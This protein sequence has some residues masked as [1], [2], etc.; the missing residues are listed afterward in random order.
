M[1]L[2]TRTAAAD[3][4]PTRDGVLKGPSDADLV[5]LPLLFIGL[6]SAMTLEVCVQVRR[7]VNLQ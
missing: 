6:D 2:S 4:R 5:L 7:L 1:E 3:M